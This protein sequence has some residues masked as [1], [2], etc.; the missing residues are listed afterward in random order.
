MRIEL[1]I[2]IRVSTFISIITFEK[3]LRVDGRRVLGRYF[4]LLGIR[5]FRNLW[6][7]NIQFIPLIQESSPRKV[8]DTHPLAHRKIIT[9]V[10]P[11]V[12]PVVYTSNNSQRPDWIWC[13]HGVRNQIWSV[14]DLSY[15]DNNYDLPP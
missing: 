6:N 5:Q 9:R 12:L 4:N 15:Q 10:D 11:L 7:I 8:H 14:N 1:Y 13:S 2:C 3:S